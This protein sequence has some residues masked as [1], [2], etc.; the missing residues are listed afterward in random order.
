MPRIRPSRGTHVTLAYEAL[1]LD[2][3]GVIVPAGGGRSIFVLPWLGRTLIGTTDNDYEGSL[4]H[5]PPADDDVAYLL[6]AV[7]AFFGTVA[8][9]GRPDRRLRGRA[10]ADLDRRPEEVGR[11]LAQGRAVRDQLRA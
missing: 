2:T 8:R 11:H 6:E 3:A 5:V 4:E 7:N 1:P 9:D 10:A